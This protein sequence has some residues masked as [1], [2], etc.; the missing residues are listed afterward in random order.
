MRVQERQ[1]GTELSLDVDV[2]F[3]ERVRP[4]SWRGDEA[5]TAFCDVRH[6]SLG[7]YGMSGEAMM[8]AHERIE[9]LWE[10]TE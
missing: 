5:V 1:E 10:R 6:G 7:T 4:R 8:K 3:F 9:G 2:N